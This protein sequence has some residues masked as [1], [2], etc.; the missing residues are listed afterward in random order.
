MVF[1]K[2]PAQVWQDLMETLVAPRA[3]SFRSLRASL[4]DLWTSQPPVDS[5]AHRA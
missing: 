3:I 5:P 1:D 2:D 4:S